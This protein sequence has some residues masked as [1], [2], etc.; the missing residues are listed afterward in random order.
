MRCSVSAL[1]IYHIRTPL[2]IGFALFLRHSWYDDL[3]VRMTNRATS[4]L[5]KREERIAQRVREAREAAGLSQEETGRA[6]GLSVVGYGHYDRGRQPFTVEM[7]FELSVV[8]SR[9]VQWFLGLDTGL[10]DTED[11]LLT[12][13]RQTTNAGREAIRTV[14]EA[15]ARGQPRR[16][17][18]SGVDST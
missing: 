17:S 7:L 11:H 14:A 12:C 8:L 5:T 13:Y 16:E 1:S 10:T 3:G 15:M 18:D 2:S 6:I 4:K 9:S